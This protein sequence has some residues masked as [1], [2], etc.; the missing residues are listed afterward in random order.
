M[1][2]IIVIVLIV[3]SPNFPHLKMKTFIFRN[4]SPFYGS[5]N[6]NVLMVFFVGIGL[7]TTINLKCMSV[8]KKALTSLWKKTT[9]GL[10]YSAHVSIKK[11][12][13]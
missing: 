3:N 4:N 12:K 5:I 13:I 6:L 9:E 8:T 10:N 11:R 2:H 1:R 7:S